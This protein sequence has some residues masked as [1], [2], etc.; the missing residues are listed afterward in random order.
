M[1]W[2]TILLSSFIT[3]IS[4]VGLIVDTVVADTLRSQV[5]GVEEL[6]VRVDNTP[7]YQPLQGKI[8]RIRIA[9]RGLEL[10]EN[11]RIES[12]ELETDPIDLN[13]NRLQEPG[14]L[15]KIQTSLNKPFQGAFR[16]VIK[17]SDLNQA[18]ESTNI[19]SQ[20]Q[21]LI[22]GLLPA[23]APQFEILTLRLNFIEKNRLGLEAELEQVAEEGETN[24]Q[25]AI[26]AEVGFDVE[27]GR[28]IKLI[29]FSATLNERK[30]SQRF[31]DLL[32]TGINQRLD[33][34]TFEERGIVARLLKLNFDEETLDIVAFVRLNPATD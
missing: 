26:A 17:E 34:A 9:S 33:L 24:N 1:E 4:P 13:L 16:V 18:L 22:D 10:I 15:K 2:F 25:L 3:A 11:L 23:Q 28:S 30:L 8:D 32:T 12:F 27:K 6:A 19:K 31:L 21:T 5:A 29:D 7:S 14:G 20:L